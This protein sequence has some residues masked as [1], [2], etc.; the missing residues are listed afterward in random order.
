MRVPHD[1][2]LG[3]VACEGPLLGWQGRAGH[4]VIPWVPWDW[5]GLHHGWH[6][7]HTLRAQQTSQLSSNASFDFLGLRLKGDSCA[8]RAAIKKWS[9]VDYWMDEGG[10]NLNALCSSSLGLAERSCMYGAAQDNDIWMLPPESNF[11]ASGTAYMSSK[12]LGM[13]TK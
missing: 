5:V 13:M 7:W 2:W 4:V 10:I 3:T 6:H 9:E 1:P 12:G 11:V 8:E